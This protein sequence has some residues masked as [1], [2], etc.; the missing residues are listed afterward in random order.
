MTNFKYSLKQSVAKNPL[1]TDVDLD[2]LFEDISEGRQYFNS[3]CD[4]TMVG[5]VLDTT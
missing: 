2:K 3:N 5:F 1:N 4:Q